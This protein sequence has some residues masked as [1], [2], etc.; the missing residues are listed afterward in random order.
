MTQRRL[1]VLGC[2]LVM[3]AS[4]TPTVLA[5]DQATTEAESAWTPPCH[6]LIYRNLTVGR[7]HP[8]G[9]Q[10]GFELAYRY[11]LFDSDSVLFRDSFVGAAATT[12]LT[13]AFTRLGVALQAQPLAILY[14]E[15]KWQFAGWYGTFD[16]LQTF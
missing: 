4:L 6:R 15:A 5:N 8:L 1:T 7:I 11:R 10:N 13:P 16:H 2:A 14:L 3:A 12:M 9:L